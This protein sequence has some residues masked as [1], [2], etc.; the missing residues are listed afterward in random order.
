M[1]NTQNAG[2][3]FGDNFKKL[4]IDFTSVFFLFHIVRFLVSY[5]CFIPFLPGFLIL[6]FLYN[7]VSLGIWKR[8]LGSSF[9]GAALVNQGSKSSF[10]SRMF[11]KE[12]FTSLP[13]ILL[14]VFYY[15]RYIPANLKEALII[16]MVWGM[17]I[18]LVILS[19]ITLYRKRLFKIRMSKEIING[20]TDNLKYTRKRIVIVYSLLLLLAGG[21]RYLHT[22][23]TNDIK[24]VRTSWEK[25]PIKLEANNEIVNSLDWSFY[26]APRPTIPSIRKYIDFLKINRRDINDYVLSLFDKYDHVILCE[27]LHPEMTQYDMI[28]NLVTDSRFVEKVG[29]VFTEIGNIDSHE[30][31]EELTDM[32]FPNDTV[33]QQALSSF[34]MENQ[35]F[36]LFWARTNWFTFLERMAKF[37]HKKEKKVNIFFTDRAN[38]KY[39]NQNYKRDSLMANNINS[40]IKEKKLNKS[41][42]IMN[43]RHAYVR[44]D[45]NCGHFI[46]QEFKGK[47]AN[48]FINTVGW[49]MSPLQYG[50]WDVA[51]EQMP[52]KA[53]AFS[54]KDS[55]FGKDRFDHYFFSGELSKLRY[56]DMFTGVI[57]YQP[58]YL[59]YMGWGFPY[60]LQPSNV[61]TLQERALQLG[62]TFNKKDYY[63]KN[64]YF[65][66]LKFQYFFLNLIDNLFFVWNLVLGVGILIYLSVGY[67]RTTYQ[68]GSHT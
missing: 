9:F 17:I 60:A 19:I 27:R 21:S 29:T 61:K 38:W 26:T 37:N 20:K 31:Y 2:L 63:W 24:T 39:K 49:D 62:V 13:G 25:L 48:V 40:I 41:L 51:F 67:A 55:P 5:F 18:I 28:Y 6:W 44:G 35:S 8:T 16:R 12:L 50:K 64:G 43:Y 47:V 59:H 34:M 33:F 66:G 58:L 57:Y 15:I 1:K 65:K 42:I 56:E 45:R 68:H 32:N 7:I 30:A 10:Y 23:F 46:S 52:E 4:L 3:S 54:L 53:Y 22:Y 11:I 14:I 36:H